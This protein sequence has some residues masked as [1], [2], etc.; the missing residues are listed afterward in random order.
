MHQ[1]RLQC[2]PRFPSCIKWGLLQGK[3]GRIGEGKR[4]EREGRKG[5][6]EKEKGEKGAPF[7][8]PTFKSVPPPLYLLTCPYSIMQTKQKYV[9]HKIQNVL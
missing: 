2:S 6:E 9:I 4:R 1:I 8:M 5:G 3:G 7:A